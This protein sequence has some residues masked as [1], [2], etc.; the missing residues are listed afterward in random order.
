MR[1]NGWVSVC[2]YIYIYT[3]TW[4]HHTALIYRYMCVCIYI[5]ICTYTVGIWYC[6]YAYMKGKDSEHMH[7][8]EE[9]MAMAEPKSLRCSFKLNSIADLAKSYGSGRWHWS[10][11]LLYLCISF[12]ISVTGLSIVTSGA[13]CSGAT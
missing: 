3:H 2:R 12:G 1:R 9:K 5:K 7:L 4:I 13:K 11:I 8:S 6:M 10:R